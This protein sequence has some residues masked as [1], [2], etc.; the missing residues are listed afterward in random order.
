M[1]VCVRV[2]MRVM[3]IRTQY[4]LTCTR[5]ILPRDCVQ[6]GFVQRAARSIDSVTDLALIDTTLAPTAMFSLM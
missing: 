6:G 3:W 2:E 1:L 5:T 4:Q